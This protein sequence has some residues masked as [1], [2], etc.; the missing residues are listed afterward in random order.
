MKVEEKAAAEREKAEAESKLSSTAA[1][2]IGKAAEV[3]I[4][5]KKNSKKRC[6]RYKNK[7]E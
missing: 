3:K 7:D 5:Y 4:V 1:S 6:A 2:G